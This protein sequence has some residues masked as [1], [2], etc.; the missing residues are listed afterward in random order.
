MSAVAH[1]GT[2]TSTGR[3]KPLRLILAAPGE[4]GRMADTPT[5]VLP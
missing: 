3:R 4:I 1:L 2:G 5:F